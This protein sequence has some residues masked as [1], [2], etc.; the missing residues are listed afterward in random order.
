MFQLTAMSERRTI[1]AARPG[2]LEIGMELSILANISLDPTRIEP[3][4]NW[5]CALS[6]YMPPEVVPRCQ[7]IIDAQ[8]L[9]L[10]GSRQRFGS[11]NFL[12]PSL[13]VLSGS[14][15]TATSVRFFATVIDLPP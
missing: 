15:E 9:R 13:A 4:V 5:V 14:A 6:I 8:R 7:A 1:G 2:D 12:I 3:Q 10:G 11:L